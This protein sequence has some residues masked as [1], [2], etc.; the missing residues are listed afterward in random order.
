MYTNH[1]NERILCGHLP[2]C[3]LERSARTI[4]NSID[5]A[6]QAQR[7]FARIKKSAI[8]LHMALQANVAA[9]DKIECFCP[10]EFNLLLNVGINPELV[11][12]Q[13]P[14]MRKA[15]LLKPF[16]TMLDRIIWYNIINC[17]MLAEVSE[18]DELADV[19]AAWLYLFVVVQQKEKQHGKTINL[20]VLDDTNPVF[21]LL[22][23]PWQDVNGSWFIDL[24][25]EEKRKLE[26]LTL[27][28]NEL[29]NEI[30]EEIFAAYMVA[31]KTEQEWQQFLDIVNDLVRWERYV[32]AQI[33]EPISEASKL[34]SM[35]LYTRVI[36]RALESDHYF[37]D[38]H[39]V[40]M[41]PILS[42][43]EER[44][45]SAPAHCIVC[46]S[47]GYEFRLAKEIVHLVKEPKTFNYLFIAYHQFRLDPQPTNAVRFSEL[48]LTCLKKNLRVDST[49]VGQSI[50]DIA[51]DFYSCVVSFENENAEGISKLKFNKVQQDA[52]ILGDSALYAI[53]DD[54]INNELAEAFL[55]LA[56]EGAE[57]GD[58]ATIIEHFQN[59]SRFAELLGMQSNDPMEFCKQTK[60]K[61]LARQLIV[62][63]NIIYLFCDA[64]RIM[65]AHND[66]YGY[67]A[68]TVSVNGYRNKL[69]T[70]SNRVAAMVYEDD[71]DL[72][73]YREKT[74][75]ESKSL[76]EQ[77]ARE[78]QLKSSTFI[79]IFKNGIKEIDKYIAER[80]IDSLLSA[81][82]KF[83]SEILRCPTC[84]LKEQHAD[85]LIALSDRICSTLVDVCKS[86][87][88]N[89][90][91][92]RQV[93][94]SKLGHEARFLPVSALDSLTTAELLYIQ[95]ASD[96]YAQKGFDY[97]CISA[98]YYQAFEEAYNKLIWKDYAEMLNKK[99]IN[100]Q[101]YTSILRK[102]KG[103]D[104]GDD[105]SAGYL[106]T[107]SYDRGYYTNKYHTAV[108]TSCTYGNFGQLL[109]RYVI[110]GTDIPRFC[111]HFAEL[112]GFLNCDAMFGD[113][114]F[115]QKVREFADAIL[116]A[117]HRRNEASHGG[118]A[119]DIIQ[120][121]ADKKV[122]LNDL[123]DVRD[124][125]L[126][127]IQQLLYLMRNSPR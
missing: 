13:K 33:C 79:S 54:T 47:A 119:I 69:R 62:S 30:L 76:S 35:T 25:A 27:E 26:L 68:D 108:Q 116:N 12:D 82:S 50:D 24:T 18:S 66:D 117:T 56:G 83:R 111:D 64:L 57:G 19:L 90:D 71:V 14:A 115:M 29:R 20:S 37:I 92:T 2:H 113:S 81:N 122:V 16:I 70:L 59:S 40:P 104:W 107:N 22:A 5:I 67:I 11:D 85:E 96:E 34:E 21:E 91:S 100:G 32:V 99:Q 84:R 103:E 124:E 78:E 80:N 28:R 127:L 53:L 123:K 105:N 97:S 36:L 74:G 94:I 43:V 121:T 58:P 106:P 1:V 110:E 6:D 61:V 31:Q 88:S 42:A 55:V 51:K 38:H 60:E 87:G 114:S 9:L 52:I 44:M 4:D 75:I 15:I 120:C 77:E 118:K 72:E 8:P 63:L 10:S 86:T 39:L 93:V 125:S 109:K 45:N 65:L 7:G 46:D 73:Q 17:T 3:K 95:Y 41:K 98:L 48:A 126:G 49:S 112:T 89:Y 101:F 102:Y 23:E